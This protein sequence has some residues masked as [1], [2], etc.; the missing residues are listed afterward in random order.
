MVHQIVLGKNPSG[1]YQSLKVDANGKLE[2]ADSVVNLNTDTLEAKLDTQINSSIRGI[3]NT[4]SIGDGS[5]N[6]TSVMLGYDRS[7]GKGRALLVDGNGVLSVTQVSSQNILPANTLNSGITDDPANSIAVGMRGRTDV[8]LANSEKFIKVSSAGRIEVDVNSMSG[9]GDASAA[10]QTTIISRLDDI[11]TGV[12][13]LDNAVSGSE[14][15]C[16]IVSSALPTGA[17]TANNQTTMIGHLDGVEGLI[18]DT[19]TALGTIDGVLDNILLK[20]TEID[21]AVDAMSAK[22]PASLGQKANSSSLSICRSSTTGA[23][24]LSARTT[25]GTSSTSTKLLCDSA[26]RLKVENNAPIELFSDTSSTIANGATFTSS[27]IS[28]VNGK[29]VGVLINTGSVNPSG[30]AK[31][32]VGFAGD[33]DQQ[34]IGSSGSAVQLPLSQIDGSGDYH[35]TAVFDCPFPVLKITLENNSGAATISS[36]KVKVYQ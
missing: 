5:T 19:N 4:D 22:L 35:A 10:N 26:G 11:K 25:I 18:G 6:H 7:G 15:Q 29:K 27:E 28:L 16:D 30:S 3:N 34:L 8:S 1:D 17:A 24:D 31:I 13:L 33:A 20:N 32:L 12:E 9:G 2:V 21:N 36:L 23:F 14:L